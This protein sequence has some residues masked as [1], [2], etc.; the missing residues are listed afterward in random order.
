MKK[1]DDLLQLILLHLIVIVELLIGLVVLLINDLVLHVLPSHDV[2]GHLLLLLMRL[3][4]VFVLFRPARTLWARPL[5]CCLFLAF[6]FFS[7]HFQIL[8]LLH[9]HQH[10]LLIKLILKHL[11]LLKLTILIVLV[12]FQF[13][14][15]LVLHLHLIVLIIQ[16]LGTFLIVFLYLVA[17]VLD[18]LASTDDL[19][20][21]A[22]S[23]HGIFKYHLLRLDILD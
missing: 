16:V 4:H 3:L 20:V 11:L 5:L 17:L 10:L 8:L 21:R 23:L 6:S 19:I 2:S 12:I 13:S 18:V 15:I 14:L 7:R 1:L 22:L 9:L